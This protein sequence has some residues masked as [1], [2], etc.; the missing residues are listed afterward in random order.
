MSPR[1]EK[2]RD[3]LQVM[4]GVKAVHVAS[5]PIREIWEDKSVWEGVVETF[6]ITGHEKAKRCYCWVFPWGNQDQYVTVLEIPPVE[7]ALTAVRVGIVADGKKK[8]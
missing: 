6:D 1:I 3:A 7:S 5:T 2:I 4:N 8:H